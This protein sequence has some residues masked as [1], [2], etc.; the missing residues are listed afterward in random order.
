MSKPKNTKP[1]YP[2][3]FRQQIVELARAGRKPKDL[4]AEFGCHAATIGEWLRRA[5]GMTTPLQAE[6]LSGD[7]RRELNELRRK[8]RQLQQERDILAKATAWFSAK[9]EHTFIASTN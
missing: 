1:P 4:A 2:A 9:S 3:E 8:N 6:P 5:D 7:E